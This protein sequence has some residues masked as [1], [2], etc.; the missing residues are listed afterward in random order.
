MKSLVIDLRG[1]EGGLSVGDIVAG[2]LVQGPLRLTNYHQYMRFKKVPTDVLPYLSTW[3]KSF[4]DWSQWT[5]PAQ[6]MKQG[7]NT[8][9]PMTR[10]EPETGDTLE[11][12]PNGFKGQVFVLVDSA[13]SS[14]TFEF[15]R[16]VQ[17]YHLGTL[18]GEPTGGNLRGINGGAF[19]FLELPHSHIEV[20]L[21]LIAEFPEAPQPNRGLVPDLVIY[22]SREDLAL[23]R[24]AVLDRVKRLI[25]KRETQ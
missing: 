21:P 14:A 16:L 4:S 12:K 24:D 13:N 19:Y 1:N 8:F 6:W 11:P 15:E 17:S 23:G 10:Y 3:D 20:D 18:V 22:P 7:G 5:K 25:A 9:F 2:Y